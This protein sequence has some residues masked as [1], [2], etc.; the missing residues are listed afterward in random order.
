M[1]PKREA[2]QIM[3]DPVVLTPLFQFPLMQIKLRSQCFPSSYTSLVF[4]HTNTE[5]NVP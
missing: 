5:E 4:L 2:S 3:L 1:I